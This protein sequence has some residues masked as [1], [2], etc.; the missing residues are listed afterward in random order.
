MKKKNSVIIVLIIGIIGAAFISFFGTKWLLS[1]QYNKNGVSHFLVITIDKNQSKEYVGEL[2]EH[3]IY[4]EKLNLEETN[5]RN[6]NAENVPIKEAIENKIVSIK[7]WKRY[8]WKI[9]KSGDTEILKYDNYEIA[10]DNNEC[11]IRPLSK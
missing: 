11:I 6:I 9:K 7:E 2:D 4:I 3:K 10:C 1:S 5:F 8:A